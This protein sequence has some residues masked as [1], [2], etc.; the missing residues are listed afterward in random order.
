MACIADESAHLLDGVC[1]IG[2]GAV[3]SREH[4]VERTGQSSHLGVGCC[5]SKAL[6]EIAARKPCGGHLHLAKW[7][8]GGG[9]QE[10]RE[11]RA[12]KN[13]GQTKQQEDGREAAHCLCGI[14]QVNPDDEG[15]GL[16]GHVRLLN[17]AQS[18]GVE[19][20]LGVSIDALDG[21]VRC[22]IQNE[23]LG[24]AADLWL[25]SRTLGF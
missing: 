20:P 22:V 6:G 15:G 12:E 19:S 17:D 14:L 25:V 5:S 7:A 4:G 8:K 9:D 18:V 13:S 11:N 24:D 2:E 3:N 1:S 23:A 21:E 10:P 16:L